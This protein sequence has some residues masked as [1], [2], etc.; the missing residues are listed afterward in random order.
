[1]YICRHCACTK[2]EPVPAN[3]ICTFLVDWKEE[4]KAEK[5]YE[6]P[7]DHPKLTKA[8]NATI[9]KFIDDFPEQL[10]CL[11]RTVGWPLSYVICEDMVVPAVAG[12]PM[13]GKPG[14][15]YGMRLFSML[16]MLVFTT[17]LTT[18]KSLRSYVIL[19]P[20]LRRL[21]SGSRG[22]PGS[23]MV[24]G[25][26]GFQGQLPWDISTQWYS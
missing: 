7:D 26:D 3:F 15:S 12:D 9:F 23:R 16:A 17:S 21:R 20:S 8:N 22:L 1:M 18:S 11:T 25:V 4:C 19:L 14:S 5:E 2:H 24:E 6:D 10:G 13:F